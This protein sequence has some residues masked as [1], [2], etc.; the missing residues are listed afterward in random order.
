MIVNAFENDPS[1][2][3]YQDV[4]YDGLYDEIERTHYANT[5]LNLLEAEFGTNSDIYVQAQQDPSSDNFHYFRGRDYDV[6]NVKILERY[7]YYNNPDGNSP[8]DNQS[9]ESY[10]T[11]G[12]TLPNV[13]DVNNDNTLNEEE[14]YYQYVIDL[15][16]SK[17][18]VG[19]NYINDV[20]EAVPEPL[21]DGSRPTTKWYQFK[22]P[23]RNPDKV[24]G[25]INGF[26]SIRF[27]RVFMKDFSEPI[28]CRLATFELVRSDWRT[29]SLDLM[30]DGDYIPGQGDGNTTINVS[31]LSYEENANRTPIPY[32]LPPGIEREQGYGGTQV[33]YVNEQALTMK[34]KDLADDALQS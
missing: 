27:M 23:I 26:H 25:N 32:V 15:S 3:Q 5:Y 10:P 24:V 22:I 21:P 7:K 4:G 18:V 14:K 9:P 30:E 11:A 31:T 33:Y 6:A 13:E 1:A 12:S 8:T 29:Y 28:I 16:P 20:F 19:E 17:M 2:R 34:V